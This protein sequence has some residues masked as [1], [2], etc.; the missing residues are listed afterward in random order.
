MN[1]LSPP[2][3]PHAQPL[4]FRRG[5]EGRLHVAIMGAWVELTP[6]GALWL[7]QERTLVCADLHLE[8]G[9]A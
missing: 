6:S 7:E 4:A 9:S 8:K 2:P 3:Q 5:E 1:A